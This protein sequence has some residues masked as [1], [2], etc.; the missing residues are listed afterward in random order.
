VGFGPP[1]MMPAPRV[2]MSITT[3]DTLP[4]ATEPRPSTPRLAGT[5]TPRPLHH[6]LHCNKWPRLQIALD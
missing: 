1:I 2:G 6:Q 3:A 5:P 4:W